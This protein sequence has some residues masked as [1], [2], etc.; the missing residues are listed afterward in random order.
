M[1]AVKRHSVLHH[2]AD[3]NPI[4]CGN[5]QSSLVTLKSNSAQAVL[6]GCT[7]LQYC[8]ISRDK[9]KLVS[10]FCSSVW[11]LFSQATLQILDSSVLW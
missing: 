4:S 6:V 5:T 7:R 1:A 8:C 9:I 2:S 10:D 3:Y 11:S